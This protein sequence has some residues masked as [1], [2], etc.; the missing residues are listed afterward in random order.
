MKRQGVALASC[1]GLLLGM[2]VLVFSGC[3]GGSSGSPDLFLVSFLE[4]QRTNIYRD[5]VLTFEFTTEVNAGTVGLD[6]FQIFTGTSQNPE[7]FTGLFEVSGSFVYFQ[8]LVDEENTG[9]PRNPYG[10]NENTT[11]QVKIPAIVDIPTPLQVLHSTGGKPMSQPFSGVFST[12]KEYRPSPLDPNPMFAT[13]GYAVWQDPG[14]PYAGTV[15]AGDDVLNYAP[16]PDRQSPPVNPTTQQPDFRA[17]HPTGV[18]VAIRF[19]SVMDP[20]S[21]RT[22]VT[23]N[24][25]LEYNSPNSQD[26]NFVPCTVSHSID[27]QYYGREFYLTAATP[28]AHYDRYNKYRLI[29][30]QSTYPLLSRGGKKLIEVVEK[31]DNTV[32]RTVRYNITEADLTFW[33]SKV[34]GET[35]PLLT[36]SFPLETSITLSGNDSDSDVTCSAGTLTA[37]RVADRDSEDVTPC[38]QAWCNQALREPLTQS[39]ASSTPNPNT[40]G[41]SKVQFH[42]NTYQHAKTPPTYKLKNAEALVGM[43]WG[44]LCSTVIKATY[45][46]MHIHVM[47]SDRNSTQ[48]SN[49]AQLPSTTYNSNFDKNPPG[50]PVRDGTSAYQIDQS[51]ANA[52]WYPW[53]F[54]QPF[55]DYWAD[56]GLVFL[57]WTEVGGDVEQYPLWY[58]PLPAPRTRVYSG[59]STAVNP[60]VGIDGQLTFYWTKFEFKRMRSLAVTKY[61]RLTQNANDKPLWNTVVVNPS[62]ANL[63]GGT[64]YR[65]EYRGAEFGSYTPHK[66]GNV[67]YY[68][69]TGSPTNV[70]AWSTNISNMDERP[71]VS[72]RVVFTANIEQPN[73]LPYLDGIA[74]T[75][76]LK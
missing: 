24:L 57:A 53:K 43:N 31:W 28:L 59:P 10:F 52:T 3:S 34:T 38:T 1:S 42:F 46:K 36:A 68:E 30:D 63:P 45:P 8:P 61:Y 66:V 44:P 72:I 32:K 60:A 25:R 58:S 37:G 26:W 74:F 22:Q 11:Y 27:E 65:I 50:F 51:S 29:V 18:Q 21:I 49:P 13:N 23:G 67:T 15:E 17:E 75:F 19:T 39:F 48:S 14:S 4:D 76:Q 54:Q 35:G 7:P 12:G 20:R 70:T 73:D 69:G 2:M 40:K 33:C 9:V 16:I 55:T 56:K 41:P 71:A 6:T 64:D 62:P 5:Q 47:W